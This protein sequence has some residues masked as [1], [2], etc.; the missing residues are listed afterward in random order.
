MKTYR[1]EQYK[2]NVRK[3]YIGKE[4]DERDKMTK[5]EHKKLLKMRA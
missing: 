1:R 5:K 3:E 2:A 4:K